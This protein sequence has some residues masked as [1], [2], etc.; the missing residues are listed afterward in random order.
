MATDC[1]IVSH[2]S[3][4]VTHAELVK[5]FTD[6]E[7]GG[8]PVQYILYPLAADITKA[9]VAFQNAKGSSLFATIMNNANIF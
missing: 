6:V 7:N 2:L 5:K 8:S 1:V 9:L 4:K 3:E